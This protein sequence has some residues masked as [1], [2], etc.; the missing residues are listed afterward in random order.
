MKR[1]IAQVEY[2]VLV[3]IF[4][5]LSF[6]SEVSVTNVGESQYADTEVTTN[7]AFQVDCKNFNRL[8]FSLDFASTPS[9]S[10]EVVI[11]NDAD[12]DGVL[13]LD[14]GD[15]TFGCDLGEWFVRSAYEDSVKPLDSA[16]L[17]GTT[18]N[19]ILRKDDIDPN[20]NLIRIIRRG[21]VSGEVVSVRNYIEGL[22]LR[23]R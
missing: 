13:S 18:R 7:V 5:M 21:N 11:G 10:L 16:L 22:N 1:I 3:M 15:F 6:G 17:N 20:W 4:P 12:A 14:E 2:V 8:E 9:N 23:I 19:F